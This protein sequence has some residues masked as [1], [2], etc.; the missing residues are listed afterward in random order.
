MVI[1]KEAG[2]AELLHYDAYERRSGLVHLFARGTTP[3]AFARA[4]AVEL[5]DFVGG[6]FHEA[7]SGTE[8]GAPWVRLARDGTAR[9]ASG[10]LPVRVTKTIAAGG[11]RRSPTLALDVRVENRGEGLLDATLGVEWAL[12]MLGGGG[13]P[14]AWY[15]I[16]GRRIRHDAA[17]GPVTVAELR[18]GNDWIGLEVTTRIAPEAEA[19]IVPIETVSSSEAGFE[20][21]YQGSALVLTW[22]LLLAAGEARSI[23][24]EHVVTTARDRAAEEAANVAR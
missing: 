16:D 10:D 2:L 15:A 9:L 24:V 12:T 3:A 17:A 6:A 18:S 8:G 22:P 7:G 21:V 1:T 14:A 5:G 11:D 13:N 19:W 4:E 23:R 20:R